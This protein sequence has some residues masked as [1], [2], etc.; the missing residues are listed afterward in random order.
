MMLLINQQV[1]TYIQN[2]YN[3]TST[4]QC[5]GKTHRYGKNKLIEQLVCHQ[6]QCPA[7]DNSAENEEIAHVHPWCIFWVLFG[8]LKVLLN[9]L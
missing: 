7:T 6:S 4:Y 8:I 1:P 9:A 5:A 3:I 2:I